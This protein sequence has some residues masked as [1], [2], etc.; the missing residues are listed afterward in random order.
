MKLTKVLI[1]S[2][3]IFFG[4]NL[5]AA[6]VGTQPLRMDDYEAI[7]LINFGWMATCNTLKLQVFGTDH[8][9]K[10]LSNKSLER[11]LRI[12]TIGLTKEFNLL[13]ASTKENVCGMIYITFALVK[14]NEDYDIYYGFIDFEIRPSPA[15]NFGSQYR[16]TH[17]LAGASKQI[18]DITKNIIDSF[19]IE[20][21]DD[22]YY[23]KTIK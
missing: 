12:K 14:Y 6:P 23:I 1:F 2:F 8:A 7:N 17:P 10:F 16:L 4:C 20:W 11:L 22:Y 3:S 21:L 9:N 19:V 13:E 5:M 18:N 15:H